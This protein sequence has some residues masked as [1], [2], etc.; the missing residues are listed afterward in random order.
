MQRTGK[1][2]SY[3]KNNAELLLLLLN[4]HEVIIYAGLCRLV[5]EAWHWVGFE[6]QALP[7]LLQSLLLFLQIQKCMNNQ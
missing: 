2:W 1:L 3:K 4:L 6:G 7:Q 5:V